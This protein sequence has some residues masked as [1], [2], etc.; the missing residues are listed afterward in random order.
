[1]INS[2][3]FSDRELGPRASTEQEISTRVWGGIVALI[4]R[5]ISLGAFGADFPEECPDGE[6]ITGTDGYTMGLALAGELSDLPWPPFAGE[7]PPTLVVLDFMEFCHRYVAK[8]IQV[9]HHGFY[10][11]NHLDF[12]REEGKSEFRD[13]INRIFNRNGVAYELQA[14]GKIQRIA[15]PVLRETLANSEFNTSDTELN[16]M[17]ASART[18]YLSPNPATRR[19]SLEKLW[20]AWE[21]VKTIEQALD[22]KSSV[23][24]L[25]DKAASE[26]K[27][28]ETL[29]A[30]ATELTRIGNT[31]RI[32][33]SETSQTPLVEDAHVDYLFHR[34]FG[35]VHMLLK[36]L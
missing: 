22:K 8:P 12:K 15:P 2:M 25:L 34:L 31:F 29:E 9:S 10:R 33:H 6:G 19:E 14:D 3:Y 20:D 5:L 23:M 30:E 24:K 26:S 4:S 7:L 21:R 36:S 35:L 13:N 16:T 17:L 27:F 28:R 32:R 11:H 1:M 18:K